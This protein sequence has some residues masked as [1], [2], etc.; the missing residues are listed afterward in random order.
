MKY[1]VILIVLVAG[2]ISGY[3]IGAHQGK[4]A[5][6]ALDSL[7][8]AAKQEKAESD[9]TINALKENMAGL[10]ADHKNEL[11]RIEAEHKQQRAKLDA[12]LAGRDRKIKNLSANISNNQQ[13]IERL[14]NMAAN[15]SDSEEKKKL[16]DEIARLKKE[17]LNLQSGVDG[18]NCL[19]IA[20]P[21]EILT[22]LQVK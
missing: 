15:V 8:Q 7:K 19:S 10:S 3:Y 21:D 13:E 14:Q 1:L 4:S 2:G 9:K 16:Q 6:E 22:R 20:A 12:V 18:L 5:I 17:K 11:A